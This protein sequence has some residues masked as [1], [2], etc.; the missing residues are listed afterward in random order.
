MAQIDL[1]KEKKE[2]GALLGKAKSKPINFAFMIGKDGPILE[3][4]ARKSTKALWGAG[5]KRG[6]G[7]GACGAMQFSKSCL[8][9]ICEEEPLPILKKS[10]KTFLSERGQ[11]IKFSLEG[12]N[13]AADED[14]SD[15][16]ET[17]KA[18]VKK[19]KKSASQTAQDDA[20]QDEDEDE[21]VVP[22]ADTKAII[23]RARKR[24]L[25]AVSVSYT[26]LTL[27]TIC[28]V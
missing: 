1:K 24:P 12:P 15:D 18:A 4:D 6:G 23:T 11:Q 8:R 19:N 21:D 10:F 5:K 2:L 16:E 9:L 13:V 7:K 14:D 27:P 17:A 28:S 3:A 22:E 26:H 25:N 20:S